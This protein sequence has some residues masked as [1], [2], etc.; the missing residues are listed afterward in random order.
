MVHIKIMK[1]KFIMFEKVCEVFAEKIGINKE[2]QWGRVPNPYSCIYEWSLGC[3]HILPFP[4]TP[5]W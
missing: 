2:E 5:S 3:S 4:G 1:E